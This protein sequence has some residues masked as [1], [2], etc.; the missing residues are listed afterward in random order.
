MKTAGSL[1]Q[2]QHIILRHAM[3]SAA[4]HKSCCL[5]QHF[6]YA[7][8]QLDA[9]IQHSRHIIPQL[10]QQ[11]CCLTG[12]QGS[13]HVIAGADPSMTIITAA[14][15]GVKWQGVITHVH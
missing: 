1:K 6:V 11:K 7:C 4:R 15:A 10:A 2:W 9:E 3:R 5:A 13:A 8:L 14:A 12:K